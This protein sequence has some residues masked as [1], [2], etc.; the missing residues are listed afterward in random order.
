V[1]GVAQGAT[2][3]EIRAA[4]SRTARIWVADRLPPELDDLRALASS[5]HA[6]MEQAHRILT[7]ADARAHYDKARAGPPAGDKARAG[8]ATRDSPRA[9]PAVSGAANASPKP[10]PTPS[11][12][13][14]V[15]FKE[16]EFALEAGRLKLAEELCRRARELAPGVG[17]YAA[18]LV[19]IDAQRAVDAPPQVVRAHVRELDNILKHEP[20]C[21][22]ALLYRGTLSKRLGLEQAA[23]RD[24]RELVALNPEHADALRELEELS[25]HKKKR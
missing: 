13:A 23:L 1:L 10:T 11:G 21:E 7:D 12:D 18:T 5:V 22:V 24:L 19:W 8:P 4:Y 6:K 16:A 3:E 15:V 14:E 20:K 17:R 25:R 2:T 9:R